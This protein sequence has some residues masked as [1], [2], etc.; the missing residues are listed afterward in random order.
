MAFDPSDV[1]LIP[2]PYRDQAGEKA[3]P[4]VVISGPSYNATGD[5]IVAAIT[6]HAARFPTDYELVDW[7]SAGLRLPSTVRMLIATAAAARVLHHVGLTPNDWNEVRH[8]LNLVF[9]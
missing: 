5:L 6:S 9:A 4:A 7:K 3:R 1:V 8:R 2:F